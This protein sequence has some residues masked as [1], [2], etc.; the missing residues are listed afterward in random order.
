MDNINIDICIATK[1]SITTLPKLLNS[2][3]NQNDL[4]PFRVLI[5]DN[6]SND[7]TIKL[8]NSYSFC[9]IISFED[10]GPEEAFNKLLNIDSK[11]LKIIIGSD[12]YIAVNFIKNFRKTANILYKKGFKKFILLP[13]FYKNFNGFLFNINFPLPIFFINFIGISRGIGF[14]IF[15]YQDSIPNFNTQ[16]LYASDFDFLLRCKKN[17]FCIK[18]VPTRYF[19]S[20]RGRSSKN[21]EVA[22]REE[23]LIS[24]KYNKANI[25]RIFIKL[26]FKLKH[27][28]R[29]L[30]TI[31]KI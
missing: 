26:L 12:D 13:M 24:L 4:R 16:I 19:H 3:E 14:G 20:K 31:L 7:G 6:K 9:K 11:N 18:Y 28:V 8:L 27:L 17:K 10:N 22:F 1:N 23:K 29:K 30:N 5:A 15:N 21:W 25:S 2:I